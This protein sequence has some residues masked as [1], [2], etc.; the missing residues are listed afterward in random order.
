MI[1]G[2]ITTSDLSYINLYLY[3]NFSLQFFKTIIQMNSWLYKIYRLVIFCVATI[4]S[5]DRGV[6]TSV[7]SSLA[8]CLNA[9]DTV[10][11]TEMCMSQP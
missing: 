7:C 11:D 6:L 3:N 4:T 1:L 2:F 8:Y 9:H 5:T 10:I